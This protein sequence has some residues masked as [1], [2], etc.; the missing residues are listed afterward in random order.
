MLIPVSTGF[1]RSAFEQMVEALYLRHDGLRLRF[2]TEGDNW[3]LKYVEFDREMVRASCVYETLPRD[4]ERVKDFIEAR[5]AHWQTRLNIGR[6]PLMRMVCFSEGT[7]SGP[8]ASTSTD[9]A[10]YVFIVFHHLIMDGVSWRIVLA[11]LNL[12]VSQIRNNED[13]QLDD[14]TSSLQQWSEA[15]GDYAD[16]SQVLLELPFGKHNSRAM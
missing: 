5:C 2:V 14:K 16:D 12:A 11:D 3:S 4:P 6:G 8:T 10:V 15:L 13:V 7:E 1:D 9:S